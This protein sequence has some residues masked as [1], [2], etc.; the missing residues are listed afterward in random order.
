PLLATL[1]GL[2]PLAT[3]L[4][5]Q[6]Q[7]YDT[8]EFDALLVRLDGALAQPTADAVRQSLGS[9]RDLFDQVDDLAARFAD[10][11]AVR[12]ALQE[13]TDPVGEAWNGP[14]AD[15]LRAGRVQLRATV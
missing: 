4:V 15:R 2:V 6:R 10:R 14:D 7:T 5:G 8:R 9:Q 13:A 1:A 3:P 11:P 12:R